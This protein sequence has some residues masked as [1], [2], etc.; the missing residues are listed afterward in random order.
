MT[1]EKIDLFNQ[2]LRA[3]GLKT[4][5][6][7]K[8]GSNIED[9]DGRFRYQLYE[10][11]PY[12]EIS[13]MLANM[14]KPER[15]IRTLD[16]FHMFTYL[17][18]LPDNCIHDFESN[19]MTIGPFL[20]RQPDAVQMKDM[21]VRLKLPD[22]LFHDVRTHYAGLPVLPDLSAFEQFLLSLGKSFFGITYQYF[23][24]PD[25]TEVNIENSPAYHKLRQDPRFAVRNLEEHYQLENQLLNAVTRGDYQN[26][27]AYYQTFI[28]FHLPPR[29]DNL[30]HN[31]RNFKIILN[32]LLRKAAEAGHVHP[33]YID[34]ISTRFAVL[35]NE[36]KALEE[37][38]LLADDMIHKYCLL[39]QN[40]SMKSISPAIRTIITYIDFHYE[41]DLGLAFFAD[42]CH[43]SKTYL[44]NL[45]KKEMDSTITDYIHT[46]RMKKALLLLNGTSLSIQT[47]A[48][49][50]GYSE[51]NYFIRLFK[52]RYGMSPKQYQKKLG[53]P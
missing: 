45:F 4:C 16:S 33:I 51:L 10:D 35:I 3:Y 8:D 49:L 18:W 22:E 37:L 26:A 9:T 46:V 42:M 21:M 44:S 48:S 30:I 19:L 32:T 6:L 27:K 29:T 5:I 28:S 17:L 12:E 24:F 52:R 1:N 2:V 14:L 40:H 34:D 38:D 11:Y 20:H 43:L 7:L 15:I 31:S 41:E 23:Y 50:C 53:R 39:V 36:A 47:I 25:Q 13:P